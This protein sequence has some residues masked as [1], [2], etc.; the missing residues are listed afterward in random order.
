M[1]GLTKIVYPV[2]RNEFRTQCPG[3]VL[4]EIRHSL[5][6]KLMTANNSRDGKKREIDRIHTTNDFQEKLSPSKFKIQYVF[7]SLKNGSES[8]TVRD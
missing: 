1:Y 5:F 6:D 4:D 3:H 2:I 8:F 7:V